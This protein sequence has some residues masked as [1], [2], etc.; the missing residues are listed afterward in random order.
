MSVVKLRAFDEAKAWFSYGCPDRP[1]IAQ[2][3]N[4]MCLRVRRI[5]LDGPNNL[6]KAKRWKQSSQLY[7][8]QA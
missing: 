7:G 3:V 5:S 6:K 8:N 2:V 4:K 1:H